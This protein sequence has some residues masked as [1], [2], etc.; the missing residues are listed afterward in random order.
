M[1]CFNFARVPT[2]KL[3]NNKLIRCKKT[4]FHSRAPQFFSSIE[5]GGSV[6]RKVRLQ[7]IL[8]QHYPPS[9]YIQRICYPE[10]D[11]VNTKAVRHGCKHEASAILAFEE[12]IKKTHANVKVVKCGLF[13]NEEH[14]WMH[15]IAEA[16]LEKKDK[17]V[18]CTN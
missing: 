15:A 4:P 13:I 9:L 7:H 18:K 16:V 12:S 3:Q 17:L 11:K 6:P 8:T 5:Q 1:N 14:P 10:L 2:L